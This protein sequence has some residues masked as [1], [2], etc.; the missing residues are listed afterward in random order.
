MVEHGH[1]FFLQSVQSQANI[2]KSDLTKSGDP[3]ALSF[4]ET[5]EIVSRKWSRSRAHYGQ[6]FPSVVHRDELESKPE[7]TINGGLRT[8]TRG[9]GNDPDRTLRRP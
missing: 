5:L 4:W 7:A 6:R 9:R 8:N 2:L 3:F 1:F